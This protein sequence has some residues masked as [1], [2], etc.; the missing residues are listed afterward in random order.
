MLFGLTN[1]PAT[2][3]SLIDI[4]LQKY[5]DI[6]VIAYLENIL[7]YI[8]STSKEHAEAVKKV[9]KALQQADM[10]LRP[11]KCELHKKEVKFLGSIITTEGTR[12]DQE[13]VKAVTKWPEPKN[14][15]EVQA[16]LGFAN[17]Y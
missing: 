11:D 14:L 6:F 16:F 3:Q 5:L 12:I 7:V 9:F 15:K 2:I 1:A 10:R 13:K 17:F 4:T 8:K